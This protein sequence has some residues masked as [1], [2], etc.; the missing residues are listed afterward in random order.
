M[1]HDLNLD[2]DL[3][4]DTPQPGASL[5]NPLL[6]QNPLLSPLEQEVLEEYARLLDNM[7]KVSG[8]IRYALSPL[9]VFPVRF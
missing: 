8:I 4:L 6:R 7:N 3:D 2:L 5:D 1:P 9:T